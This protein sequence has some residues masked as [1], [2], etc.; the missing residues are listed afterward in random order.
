MLHW[1]I[2]RAIVTSSPFISWETAQ[3]YLNWMNLSKGGRTL[4]ELRARFER[5]AGM[6][7]TV[8]RT[9]ETDVESFVMPIVRA[10]RLPKSVKS[11]GE[12][13]AAKTEKGGKTPQRGLM[14]DESFFK[15]FIAHNVPMLKA[16][17]LLVSD[18]PQLQQYIC[19]LGWRSWA[20]A[21]PALIPWVN[22]RGQLLSTD[23]NERRI[24]QRFKEAIEALKIA[25]PELRA[26]VRPRGLWIS[27]PAKGIQFIPTM[28]APVRRALPGST[29][30]PRSLKSGGLFSVAEITR[31]TAS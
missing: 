29:K 11:N 5:I 20:A 7:I 1:M 24:R 2:N 13:T 18:R 27:P 25:W 8:Q 6:A 21:A 10:S 28:P 16:L 14:F 15:D 30:Y 23:S 22:L 4:R 26:E 31:E 19:F 3:E 17:L 12:E 9:N